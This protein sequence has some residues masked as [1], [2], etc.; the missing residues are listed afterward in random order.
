LLAITVVWFWKFRSEPMVGDDIGLIN[1]YSGA[2]H[3][4]G[5]LLTAD[6][7]ANRWRPVAN[8][9]FSLTGWLFGEQF[10]AWWVINVLIL[11]LTAAVLAALVRRL[12]ASSFA[13]FSAALLLITSR[14]TLYQVITATGQIEALTTLFAV[15]FVAAGLMFLLD[16]RTS[17]LWIAW[18]S[19]TLAAMTHERFQ[20]LLV[21]ALLM[22]LIADSLDARR[23]WIWA[24]VFTAPVL[25]LTVVKTQVF[26]L[27]LAVGTGTASGVGFSWFST[28]QHLFVSV[29]QLSGMNIGPTYLVGLEFSG[30]MVFRALVALTLVG[31]TAVLTGG[32]AAI[33]AAVEPRMVRLSKVA[34]VG[35]FLGLT[36][37]ACLGA[38]IITSNLQQRWLVVPYVVLVVV[39]AAGVGYLRKL[40]PGRRTG[41]V[42]AGVA[43]FFVALTLFANVK[44][45]DGYDLLFFRGWQ[46]QGAGQLAVL[47]PA[48][49]GASEG[50]NV[51]YLVDPSGNAA[52][53]ASFQ[54]LYHANSDSQRLPRF[55]VVTERGAVPG[56]ERQPVI[57]SVQPDGI[58]NRVR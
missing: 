38:S 17:Y 23:K 54:A 31:L 9:A 35:S 27:P 46:L 34:S 2:G 11:A 43:G 29:A 36:F 26:A 16:R 13:A 53:A 57:V 42:L 56:D 37:V 20:A 1:Y 19:L 40:S 49:L 22:I 15:L 52:L 28:W 10:T 58:L 8:V 3:S 7:A 32:P 18:L 48:A 50:S 14:F 24:V 39:I 44:Y 55:V 47:K 45:R 30:A 33:A 25:I 12:T 5:E 51:I 6:Q 41:W 4:I 21:P